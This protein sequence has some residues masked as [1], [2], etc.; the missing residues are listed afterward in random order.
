MLEWGICHL[1]ATGVLSF[2]Y[3][4]ADSP[5][6]HAFWAVMLTHIREPHFYMIHRM[7]HP[8]RNPYIPDVGKFLYRHVHS[9]H[10]KSYNTTALSGTSMHPIESTMYYACS[11][12]AL[13]FGCHPIIPVAM[14]IDAGIGAWLGHGGFIFPGTGDMYHT[15]HHLVFDA[16]YGTPNIPIDWMLGTFAATQ[17]DVKG[18]WAKV[19]TKVGMEN[20][21]TQ[22]HE[23]ST[24]QKKVD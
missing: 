22:V 5:I 20:S 1:M 4:M 19:N 13:P 18:I 17:D 11:F 6:K 3:N 8:W 16:N 14:I 10:H 9:L 12:L 15:I 24:S 23:S 7:M 2:N 21:G